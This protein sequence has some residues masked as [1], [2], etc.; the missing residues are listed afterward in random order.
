[1][2]EVMRRQMFAQGGY[3]RPMQEGG[4]ASMQLMPEQAPAMMQDPAMMQA[5]S[6]PMAPQEMGMEQAA[7]GAAAQG[8]DPAQLQTMLGDYDQQMTELG[9]AEN[10]E[11]V[12]NSI[13]GDQLPMEAR[14]E[15]LASMVGPEDANATPESVLTLMQPVM[16][17]AAVDQG[18]GGLAQDEMMAPIEGPMAEGIM[19]TVNMGAAEGPA[20]VNFRYG[21]AVQNMNNGGPVQYMNNGGPATELDR[22]KELFENTRTLQK[23]LLGAGDNAATYA[24]QKNMTEAQMLFDIAQGALSFASPGDRQM[25]PAERL[26]QSFSPVLGSIGAR[27]GELNKFKQA[28][29]AEDKAMD[30]LALQSSQA[31]YTAERAAASA[32]AIADAE[33]KAS[34]LAASVKDDNTLL[35]GGK[36][37]DVTVT[38]GDETTIYRMPLT[39]G[40][41]NSLYSQ[42][43]D[44]VDISEPRDDK[45]LDKTYNITYK[46]PHET[47]R[48]YETITLKNQLKT[49][50]ELAAIKE[51]DPDAEFVVVPAGGSISYDTL[52]YPEGYKDESGKIKLAEMFQVGSPS[53]RKAMEQGALQDKPTD[54]PKVA[55][56]NVEL[57]G[58]LVVTINPDSERYAELTRELSLGGIGGIEV[59]KQA[60]ASIKRTQVTLKE[61][62]TVDGVSYAAGTNPNFTDRELGTLGAN[63][64]TAY[65][66]PLEDKD[67][68]TAYKMTKAEFDAQTP[69]IK[70]MLQGT[71]VGDVDYFHKFGVDMKTF[72]GYDELT[73][74]LMLGIA[75]EYIFKEVPSEDGTQTDIL[76]ID[77]NNPNAPQVSIYSA[78]IVKDPKLMKAMMPG[79]N[80]IMISTVIDIATE[81]GQ[82]VMAK[83]NKLNNPDLGGKPGSASLMKMGTE[84]KTAQAYMLIDAVEGGGDAVVMSYD[85]GQT[86]IGD[87]GLPRQL[88]PKTVKLNDLHA[89]DVYRRLKVKAGAKGELAKLD[90]ANAVFLTVPMFD[91]NGEAMK[92]GGQ[93]ISSTDQV[94][95]RDVMKAVRNG[96]GLWSNINAAINAIAGGAAPETLSKYFKNTEEGRQYVR[97]VR[98]LGR[99]ALA[100][101]PRFAEGDLK[102]TQTLFADDSTILANPVTE[103]NKMLALADALNI[104]LKAKLEVLASDIP[105]DATV[106]AVAQSKIQEI[107]RLQNFLGPVVSMG[108]KVN[109]AS[110]ADISAATNLMMEKVGN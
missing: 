45:P 12:I 56:V 66:P 58:G 89:A 49:E 102:Q 93:T 83:I 92:N 23:S 38:S 52:Y 50:F 44:S 6:A 80:G 70:R 88:P 68:M 86:Y 63:D 53:Y 87:D 55:D 8:I 110:P 29:V 34:I 51:I 18:I 2:N 5:P 40:A 98:V 24:D 101:S 69:E 64:Y 9:E 3:V 15:E 11:G 32:A 84:S 74:K 106:V 48:G 26:S 31:T 39:K 54:R 13:R 100:A 73:Q 16:Q 78:D 72:K 104:E 71:G 60:T 94:L 61:N 59:T 17:L 42:G 7:Q 81:E 75:P 27:A 41:Q 36:S 37:F 28:Q 65:V 91:Q 30:R 96:T 47:R 21:G 57:P 19:S 107:Y 76:R 79:E 109:S 108:T 99:S 82:A 103:A 67:Y 43:W 62:V 22:Q 77:K 20:P 95:V 25:S 46:K 33:A 35:N 4:S 97:M 85:G 10:Y 105:Q 1:M 14:Y 90:A